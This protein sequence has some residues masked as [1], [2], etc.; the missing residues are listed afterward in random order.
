MAGKNRIFKNESYDKIRN[1]SNLM[2]LGRKLN[3]SKILSAALEREMI[4][5]LEK[6]FQDLE[7]HD[8][9]GIIRFEGLIN[10]LMKTHSTLTS[11][12]GLSNRIPE[13]E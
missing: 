8:I 7:Q 3:L 9:C 5:D 12:L 13:E 6:C 10:A 2:L 4:R 1:T 11:S